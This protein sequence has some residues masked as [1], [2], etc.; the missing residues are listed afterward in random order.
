MS[1]C[2]GFSAACFELLIWRQLRHLLHV[3]APSLHRFNSD[4]TVQ[5]SSSSYVF[6]YLPE[7]SV[8]WTT[9]SDQSPT[10]PG[11]LW[12]LLDSDSF[13]APTTINKIHSGEHVRHT[14]DIKL[15]GADKQEWQNYIQSGRPPN[16]PAI[17][18]N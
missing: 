3:I 9:F 10:N 6:T 18:A 11:E 2:V 13:S 8:V 7:V 14:C 16:L 15:L 4:V 12:S 1:A 5:Q 17:S